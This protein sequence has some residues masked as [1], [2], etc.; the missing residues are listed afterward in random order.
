[1]KEYRIV[2]RSITY[3]SIIISAENEFEAEDKASKI[4]S[5]DFECIEDE[6]WEHYKTREI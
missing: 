1:M 5:G 6:N 4:D 3:Y 2:Y